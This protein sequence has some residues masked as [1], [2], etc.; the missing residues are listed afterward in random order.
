MLKRFALV[1]FALLTLLLHAERRAAAQDDIPYTRPTEGVLLPVPSITETREATALAVNPANLSFLDSWNLVYVGAWVQSQEHLSGQGHGVFFGFPIGPLSF[2]VAAEGLTPPDSV[3]SWQGLDDRLRFSLGL[4][5]HFKR[6]VSLGLAYRTLWFY[7]AGELHTLDLGLTVHPINYL[8]ISFVA[9]DVTAPQYRENP[10]QFAPRRFNVGLTVRPLA[11]DRL[12]LS[13][14]LLYLY[15]DDYRR[16]D[17][18]AVLS[19][20]IV[21]G[22]SL[23]AR[24][25]AEGIRNDDH[26]T[27]YFVDGAVAFDLPNI[28]VG[29]SMHGQ[30]YPDD[31]SRYEGTTWQ[32]RFSGDEAPSITM[33]RP[34]RNSHAVLL[35]VT[36]KLGTYGLAGYGRLFERILEDNGVDMVV[37][38]PDP[39]TLSLASAQEFRRHIA[40]LQQAGRKV[41][42]YFTEA[43]GPVYL[44]CAGADHVWINPAGAVRMSGLVTQRLYFKNLFDKLGV[45]AD[46][47]RIGAYKSAPE[48]FTRSGPSEAS[49]EQMDRY[50]DTVYEQILGDLTEDRSLGDIEAAKG[51]LESGPYTAREA[52]KKKLVDKIVPLD[53]LGEELNKLAGGSLFLDDRYGQATLRHRRYLDAPAVAVVHINGDIVDGENLDIPILDIQMTGAETL[54]QILRQLREDRLISAVVLR[55]NSPGGSAM[56][57]DI[58]W[59]EVM[60]LRKEKPVIASLG[61]VAASGAYAIASAANEIYSEATTL[62]GSIG[63]YYGKADL[64]GLLSK[65]GIDVTTF[66]RGEH[67]DAESWARPYTEKERERLKDL[68]RQYY[69][70]FRERV[71]AGR[72]RGFTMEIVDKLGRGRIWSGTDA[73]HHLLVDRIGG[74]Y[75]AIDR[76]RVLGRVPADIRVFHHPKPPGSVIGRLF[77]LLQSK[78]N[79]KGSLA[80]SQGPLERIFTRTSIG[81][82]LRSLVPFAEQDPDRPQARLPFASIP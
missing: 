40:K 32:V 45:K 23:R 48:Q 67:A 68:I 73:K 16:T 59:R 3:R 5:V 56:A 75:D 27:G 21:D 31:K 17:V 61:S 37:L 10:S 81:R 62:T 74:L 41:V 1:G 24:F 77:N 54:V 60:A 14:E 63:I 51:L 7:D 38:R 70:L 35:K 82:L 66:K 11:N 25:G 4:S 12:S 53:E 52:E 47:V 28:G 36:Q 76:A 72:G 29:V 22:I 64:S 26:E 49:V 6:A 15:G 34:L 20:M 80:R 9:S 78:V 30:V 2:G 19:G 43:T 65:V 8:A 39:E 42:C 18:S 46:I 79:F 69:D 58:V 33:P 55:I 13:G 57:S 50:L 44:G 71:V